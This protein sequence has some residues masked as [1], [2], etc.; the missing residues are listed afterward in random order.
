M[1]TFLNK[2]IHPRMPMDKTSTPSLPPVR[3]H[4]NTPRN[5][6]PLAPKPSTIAFIQQFA[7]AYSFEPR[8]SH[9]LGGY[10]AN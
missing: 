10:I 1:I 9:S 2:T 3:R 4:R 5:S 7:R 6:K 8:I